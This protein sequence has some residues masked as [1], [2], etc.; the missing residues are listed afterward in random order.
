MDLNLNPTFLV[1][2]N[3][4]SLQEL[5]QILLLLGRETRLD[6]NSNTNSGLL[7]W[8]TIPSNSANQYPVT[9]KE[10]LR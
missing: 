4:Q 6:Y 1:A 10:E 2:G 5:N 8:S 9:I 3:L 7:Q